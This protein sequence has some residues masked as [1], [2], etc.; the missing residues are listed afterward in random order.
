MTWNILIRHTGLFQ[1]IISDRDPK[2]N[3]ALWTS[4]YNLFG[5][6]LSFSTA[7]NPQKYGLAEEVIQALEDI[8]KRFCT[9]GQE[10]KDSD[11]VTHDWCTLI[12]DLEL[13]YNK[14]IY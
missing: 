3:S 9:Y 12:P 6:K 8:I 1:N 5:K 4:I 7:Y 14:S 10:F 11:G 13:E 2:F